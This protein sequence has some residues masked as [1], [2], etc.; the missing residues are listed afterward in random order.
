MVRAE[1]VEG[2]YL[3]DGH[4]P[5]VTGE[6]FYPEFL[7]GAAL[8]DGRSLFAIAPLKNQPGVRLSEP[9]R[10]AAMESA[11][12]VTVDFERFLIP[13]ARVASVAPEGWIQRNDMINV[14]L[15]RHFALGCAQAALD[16][17]EIQAK[18]KG[19]AAI[20]ETFEAL[21]RELEACREAVSPASEE[22]L[23]T[24]IRL[25]AR[26][27]TI[28]LASRCAQAAIA[29]TGGSANSLENAAQRIYRETIVYT[30]S[31]QTP[32]IMEATLRRLVR[33]LPKI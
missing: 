17:I 18:K 8:S 27:W 13:D 7:L 16:L 28:E 12:T 23:S 32:P 10:L 24:D 25:E 33:P 19:N 21:S 5:W 3:I 26:A 29:A 15:Q 20:Q 1:R 22:E 14:A 2:G 30:V 4:V 31:A 9:M 6:T 11:R